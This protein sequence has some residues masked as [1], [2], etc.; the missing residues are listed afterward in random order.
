MSEN[1]NHLEVWNWLLFVLDYVIG[2]YGPMT[3]FITKQ[4]PQTTLIMFKQEVI[5]LYGYCIQLCK[6]KH[7]SY[8]TLLEILCLLVKI[9]IT[10]ILLY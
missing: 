7:G 9:I 3:K 8:W 4:L 6:T 5:W 1:L 2:Q 10:T